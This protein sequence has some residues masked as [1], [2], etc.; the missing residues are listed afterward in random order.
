ML[1]GC[2]FYVFLNLNFDMLP[3]CLLFLHLCFIILPCVVLCHNLILRCCGISMLVHCVWGFP[4]LFFG[5]NLWI[6]Q[7]DRNIWHPSPFLLLLRLLSL[8]L[9]WLIWWNL[10]FFSWWCEDFYLSE[11]IFYVLGEIYFNQNFKK[12]HIE[13]SVLGVI[14]TKKIIYTYTI[15][16]CQPCVIITVYWGL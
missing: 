16:F 7:N 15:Y 1:H 6:Y 11:A 9:V 13:S 3:H 10:H 12:L 2:R 8:L 5:G 4:P 14:C